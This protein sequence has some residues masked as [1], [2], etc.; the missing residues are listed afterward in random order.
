MTYFVSLLLVLLLSSCSF[1]SR[2]I[3][4]LAESKVPQSLASLGV[5]KNNFCSEKTRLQYFVEDESILKFYKS[6]D[7]V[8]KRERPFIQKAI[9]MALIELNRRPDL[10]SPSSRLQVFIKSGGKNHYFDFRPVNLED[11]TKNPFMAGLLYLNEKFTTKTPLTS[12]ADEL[13]AN[14]PQQLPVSL[15]L[16]QFLASSRGNLQ[17]SEMM[18]ARFFKGDET[19]TRY[20]TFHRMSFKNIVNRFSP[21]KNE[22]KDYVFD[23]NPLIQYAK[24]NESEIFCNINL[25]QEN[26]FSDEILSSENARIHTMGLI[27]DDNIFLA[28]SSG[29]IQRPLK[30]DKKFLFMKMRSLPF[31]A[32]ICDIRHEE[33]NIILFSARGRSPGQHLKHLISYEVDKVKTPSELN[34]LLRFSR[35]LF[36]NDPDRILYESK[37]GR[38]AQ[39]DFFLSMNFPIYHVESL[40]DVFASISTGGKH[41]LIID[42][43]DTTRLSC[44][45]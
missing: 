40:G 17:N 27:E 4:N 33:K 38:K 23:K 41:N 8:F 28:V 19:I 20:E 21:A 2:K 16:E 12:L 15:D 43:R 25:D 34:E 29:V 37:R 30:F 45:K 31:A 18:T 13:D 5:K 1:F 11:D 9:M 36:L 24:K 7:S 10:L 26:N 14:I 3:D 6:L 42:E 44:P 22:E 35:H 39:L 32:P